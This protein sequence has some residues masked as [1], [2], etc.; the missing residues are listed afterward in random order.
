MQIEQVK[1]Y[2]LALQ[3]SIC[4]ALSEEDGQGS[5]TQDKWLRPE[6]GQG[7]SRVL[8]DGAVFEKAGVNFSHVFGANL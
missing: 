7:R 4:A 3:D 5:F 6:G 8:T 2:L 1:T